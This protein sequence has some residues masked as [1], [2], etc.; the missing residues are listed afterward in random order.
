MTERKFQKKK[1]TK[2]RPHRRTGGGTIQREQRVARIHGRPVRSLLAVP[3]PRLWMSRG[4]VG[5]RRR[6]RQTLVRGSLRCR[7]A[8]VGMM[9]PSARPHFAQSHP[10]RLHDSLR[11]C[12][13]ALYAAPVKKNIIGGTTLATRR[14]ADSVN[15]RALLAPILPQV[16]KRLRR[17]HPLARS[18][19]VL[20]CPLT[21][22]DHGT[23]RCWDR[24]SPPPKPR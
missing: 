14:L 18:Q 17:K 19:I 11:D 2:V 6:A 9:P 23:A 10:D 1:A 16:L 24:F 13:C 3:C 7:V 15:V 22:C 21:C 8:V 12:E 4:N 5:A 20:R